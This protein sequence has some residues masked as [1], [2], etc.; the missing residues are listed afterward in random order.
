MEKLKN[1]VA[2]N[3][4][5]LRNRDHMTQYELGEKLNYSDK[6]ISRWER[7]EAIPDAYVLFQ[8]SKIFCVS[9][10]YL[11]QEHTPKE[12]EQAAAPQK[13]KKLHSNHK[14]ITQITITGI[15]TISLLTF[16]ILY[17]IGYTQW[18]VFVYTLPVSIIVLLVLNSI[19]GNKRNNLFIISALNWSVLL[20]LYLTFLYYRQNWWILFLVGIPAQVIICLCFKI[21]INQAIR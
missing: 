7:A 18:L 13:T 8:M 5:Y 10:D 9:I 19:W 21:R 6:A 17:L 16:I 4:I 12:M 3:I 20:T 15:W 2:Q 1:I 14:T 11:F